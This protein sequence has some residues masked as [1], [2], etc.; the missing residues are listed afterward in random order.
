MISRAYLTKISEQMLKV[1]TIPLFGKAPPFAFDLFASHLTDELQISELSLT[2]KSQSWISHEELPPSS[3]LH[4]I[5]IMPLTTPIYWAMSQED[6]LK[7]TSFLLLH[8][9]KKKPFVSPLLQ[10]GYYQFLLLKALHAAGLISP[11]QQMTLILHKEA[12]LPKEE[13]L[14][15]KIAITC[16]EHTFWGSLLIPKSF[17][18]GWIE[19]F[20][21]FPSA[22]FS[23][24]Q[25][26]NLLLDLGLRVG[27][28]TLTYKEWKKVK[29]G[30]F[31][32]P[33]RTLHPKTGT[34]CLDNLPLFHIEMKGDRIHLKD[35]AFMIED[36]ME[37][38]PEGTL[39]HK[40]EASEPMTK[41]LQ[42]VPL[43]VHVELARL[44]MSLDQLMQ[45]SPGNFLELPLHA[46]QTV[47]L[48]V[49]GQKV[50]LAELVTLGETLGL[51]ILEI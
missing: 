32:L 33:D 5:G 46:P 44:K 45:L 51:K 15:L 48:T 26:E 39:T 9:T 10:E 3:S 27:A 37:T 20:S 25:K 2:L 4:A 42:D 23:K 41:A 30:D 34:L 50:G 29:R 16:D 1:D 7:L 36:T 6:K 14:C 19:H 31:L 24:S 18:Q 49:G 47:L 22:L 8:K 12:H 38:E 21:A 28:I 40:L 17:Q 13:M 35:Y 43:Q 11:L